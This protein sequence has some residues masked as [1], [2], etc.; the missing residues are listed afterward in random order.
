MP[1]QIETGSFVERPA[2]PVAH[3]QRVVHVRCPQE[4][5]PVEGDACSEGAAREH[6]AARGG[7]GRRGRGASPGRGGVRGAGRR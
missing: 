5:L 3:A 2:Q 6:G 1:D 4:M 7:R